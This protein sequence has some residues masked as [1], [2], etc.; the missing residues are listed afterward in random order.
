MFRLLI[1]KL[2]VLAL[3]ANSLGFVLPPSALAGMIGTRDVL[4]GQDRQA[5]LERIDRVLAQDEVRVRLMDWGVD[6]DQAR[7]RA[8]ALTDA[9]LQVLAA[10]LDSEPVGGNVLG[11]IGAVFVVLIILELVGVTNVFNRL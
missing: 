7:M 8:E 10:R 5:V 1:A 4:E 2:L 3:V 6:P 9:E 11:L